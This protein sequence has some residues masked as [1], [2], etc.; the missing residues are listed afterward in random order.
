MKEDVMP[1]FLQRD[2]REFESTAGVA[3]NGRFLADEAQVVAEV[4]DLARLSPAER[5]AGARA[6]AASK[7]S[8]SNTIWARRRAS[9]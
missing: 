4:L 9:S 6:R 2:E 3:I 8:C 5:A 1:R 7:P